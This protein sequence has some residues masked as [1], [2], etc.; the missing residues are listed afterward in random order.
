M[1]QN[2]DILLELVREN[3]EKWT[4]EQ[5]TSMTDQQKCRLVELVYH[6]N[7]DIKLLKPKTRDMWVKILSGIYI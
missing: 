7:P 5:Y 1:Q 3:K 2:N 6:M 4:Q